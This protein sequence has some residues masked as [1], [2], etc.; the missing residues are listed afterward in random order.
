MSI[1]EALNAER[2]ERLTAERAYELHWADLLGATPRFTCIGHD[3]SAPLICACLDKPEQ[4]LRIRPYF[5]SRRIEDHAATCEIA[6]GKGETKAEKRPDV[7]EAER[8]AGHFRSVPA[9]SE[10][11]PA[12]P[13]PLWEPLQRRSRGSGPG[14][15]EHPIA[16]ESAPTERG[17]GSRPGAGA[18]LRARSRNYYRLSS[19]VQKFLEHR[20]DKDLAEALVEIGGE[21]STYEAL[22]RNVYRQK[23]ADQLTTRAIW[24]GTASLRATKEGGYY[25][26]FS[27]PFR[28]DDIELKPTITLTAK[29]IDAYPVRKL[30]RARLDKIIAEADGY[31]VVFVW[32]KPWMPKDAEKPFVRFYVNNLDHI[33]VRGPEILEELK[34]TSR[35]GE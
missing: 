6:H 7:F 30:L 18:G 34:N 4:N 9:G 31:C 11:E 20:R 5:R 33:D 26:R 8:P 23:A 2:N 10:P 35:V 27:R 24:W 32:A 14:S 13:N 21:T 22:F 3:C 28:H 12:A 15:G 17:T 19:L 29:E 1:E 16:D 25:L